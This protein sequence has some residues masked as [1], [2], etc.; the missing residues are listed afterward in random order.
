MQNVFKWPWIIV[1][2]SSEALLPE[3]E[4]FFE[5]RD[6]RI[7]MTEWANLNWKEQTWN[8]IEIKVN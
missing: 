1:M 6:L 7:F 8:F 4:T 3:W 2:N 5:S